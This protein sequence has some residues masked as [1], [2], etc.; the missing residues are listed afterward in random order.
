MSKK[1][2]IFILVFGLSSLTPLLCAQ[3]KNEITVTAKVDKNTIAQDEKL[4][5]TVEISGN[6]QQPPQV[7]LPSLEDFAILASSQSENLTLSKDN[8]SESKI[9]LQYILMPKK[10]G[11]LTI[12]SFAAKDKINS[13]KSDPLSIEVKPPKSPIPQ[14]PEE[15]QEEGPEEEGVTL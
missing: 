2:F 15:G 11:T 12:G 7:E 4:K 6:T 3:D 5:L 14:E 10:Q 8:K 13:Y 1:T 9:S